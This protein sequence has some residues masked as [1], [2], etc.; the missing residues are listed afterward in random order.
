MDDFYNALISESTDKIP[1]EYDWFAPLL[2]E[3]DF[4]YY[5]QYDKDE[6]RHVIGEWLFRRVLDGAGIEDLFICP[7]RA[8]RNVHP[9]PDAEYGAAIRM[10][11]PHTKAY[12]MTY[13]VRGFMTRLTFVKE[14]DMLVGKPDYDENSRWVFR[15]ITDNTF[16]WQN[17]TVLDNNDRRV[18][19]NIYA[20]RRV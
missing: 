8:E 12:D 17:I 20:K 10:F 13:T 6:P 11:N 7:S 2:G 16:I 9:Q 18:N 1:P 4:D 5:D 19:V 14:N 15:E 3:W